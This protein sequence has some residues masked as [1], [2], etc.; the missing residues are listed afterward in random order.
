[1][2]SNILN[3]DENARISSLIPYPY[4]TATLLYQATV[5]GWTYSNFHTAVDGQ[6]PTLTVIESTNGEFFGA[7]TDIDLSSADESSNTNSG[8]SFQFY[9]DGYYSYKIPFKGTDGETSEMATWGSS[10]LLDF[11]EGLYLEENCNS[12][13]NSYVAFTGGSYYGYPD[14][15]TS[16][17]T[18]GRAFIGDSGA[19]CSSDYVYF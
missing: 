11:I 2:S 7:Y 10:S 15:Y 18:A 14:G 3:D 17:C 16:A 12:N 1:M 6:G 19:T 9:T 8:N 4:D 13:S 5:D